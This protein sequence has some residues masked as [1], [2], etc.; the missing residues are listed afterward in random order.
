MVGGSLIARW[1][2]P[3][4]FY[5][6][7]FGGYNT[8]TIRGGRFR[9]RVPGAFLQNFR[10]MGV[11]QDVFAASLQTSKSDRPYADHGRRK[12]GKNRKSTELESY[13][14]TGRR[15]CFALCA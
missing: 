10:G 15:V 4:F 3:G 11:M 7:P 12:R 5:K 13:L 2:G 1:L 9:S 6:T 14:S 8:N